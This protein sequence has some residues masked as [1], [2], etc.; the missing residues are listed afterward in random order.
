MRY[1]RRRRLR[2]IAPAAQELSF[3]IYEG[4]ELDRGESPIPET[5]TERIRT[6]EAMRT[7]A[8]GIISQLRAERVAKEVAKKS[9]E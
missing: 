9:Q 5:K 4:R 1:T 6:D 7:R 2:M 8:E 3:V